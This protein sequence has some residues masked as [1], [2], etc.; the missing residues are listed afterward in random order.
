[1]KYLTTVMCV[2][3][4]SEFAYYYYFDFQSNEIILF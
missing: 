2:G 3:D 1:M 4:I